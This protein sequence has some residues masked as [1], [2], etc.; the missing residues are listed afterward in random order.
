[1]ADKEVNT[2]QSDLWAKALAQLETDDLVIFGHKQA[3]KGARDKRKANLKGFAEQGVPTTHLLRRQEESDLTDSERTQLFTI[4]QM[5]RR[6]LSLWDAE[7]PEEFE[8]LMSAAIATP[9]ASQDALD[10]LDVVRFYGDG[11]N[12]ARHGGETQDN[13]KQSPGSLAH[14]S[15]ARGCADGLRDKELAGGLVASV[16]ER[17]AVA[18]QEVTDSVVRELAPKKA[19]ASRKKAEAAPIEEPPLDGEGIFSDTPIPAGILH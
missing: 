17:T 6:A 18:M 5:S 13:N 4:E 10:G 12:C 2:A 11:Y 16:P 8:R 1:M 19:R 9:P 3:L 14:Q 15:W 7:S